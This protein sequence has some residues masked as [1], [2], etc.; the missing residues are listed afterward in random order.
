M[1]LGTEIAGWPSGIPLLPELINEKVGFAPTLH[2][3]P[4]G[5]VNTEVL[6]LVSARSRSAAAEVVIAGLDVVTEPSSL[7]AGPSEDVDDRDAKVVVATTMSSKAAELLVV[8]MT[9][10]VVVLGEDASPDGF[11]GL[12]AVVVEVVPAASSST[13]WDAVVVD[14]AGE[15]ASSS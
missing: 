7:R 11:T 10:I 15:A 3:V 14:E 1:P 2:V 6:E 5:V 8:V 4:L 9:V 13:V 12:S